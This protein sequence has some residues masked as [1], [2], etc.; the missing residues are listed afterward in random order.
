MLTAD[1]KRRIDAC[2]DIL[3]GKLPL[4]TDQVELITLALIYKFMDDLDEE[5][6]RMGGKRSFFTGPLAKYRWRN[7]L[8]QTVSAEQR[9]TLFSEGI[10]ALGDAQKSAHLPGLFRDIFRNAF[11]KFRDG[12]IL[13]LFLTE[14]NGFEYSHSEEL[15]NA[16]EYLLQSV[17]TQ[18]ENGQFR[19]PRH[20]IDFIVTCLDPQPGEKILDPACGTGG[21]LVSAYK[22]ILKCHTS[23]PSPQPSPTGRGG[24]SDMQPSPSGSGSSSDRE[25]SPTGTKDGQYRGGFTFSGLKA[26]AR[27]LRKSQTQPEALLWELLRDRQLGGAKFRRQ[28]QFGEYICDFFCAEAKLDVEC[29]GIA[30]D[31]PERRKH[32][33]KRDAWLKA[34]GITVLRFRNSQVLDATDSVLEEIAAHLPSETQPGDTHAESAPPSP[35]GRG[36]GGEGPVTTAIP[37]DKLTHAQ[38]QAVYRSLTGYDITD[39]MVKLSKVNL[40]LHGFPNPAIHIYDTLS[41]D[42]RWH[43]KADLILAN[44]PFMTPKGGVTPHTKFRIAARKAEVLFTDYIA[45]HLTPDGRAGVIVPNGIVATTQNAYVKLRRFLVEDSLVA[46]VSLPAGVF[47]PYSGVKTS[48]LLLDK[49]LARRTKEILFL[50]I[51]AD[52]FDL[53]DKRNPIE[54]NDLPEAERV[55]KAWLKGMLND[56]FRMTNVGTSATGAIGSTKG[57][58][59]TAKGAALRAEGPLPSQPGPTAQETESAPALRAESPAQRLAWKLVA[60]SELLQHRACSLQAEPFLGNGTVSAEIETVRL[61]DV[62]V[63]CEQVNPAS[64]GRPTF[65]YIDIDSVD[66]IGLRITEPKSLPVGEAPSRARKL[67]KAR[68][69]LFSTV[70]PYLKNIAIVPDSLDGE[71]ASTGFGVLRADESRVLPEYLF[72]VVS[73]QRFVDAA[74]DLTT[75]ASYPAITE[76]QLFDLEIPLPPLEEQRRI[77]AEI[78][79]YQNEIA[80]LESE[81]VANRERIQTTIDAVWNGDSESA[82]GAPPSQL[83]AAPQVKGRKHNEG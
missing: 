41:N 27:E 65:R 12:R 14:V 45:E 42:A 35:L 17:G 54:A 73:N 40:F 39:L 22:H 11:L 26:R 79:G 57:A 49:K 25:P 4:P 66:N 37:G 59:L 33:A 16:F 34:R 83:G 21:F 20:I 70:R 6:V 72:A 71:I 75:G 28:H 63:K 76:N 5:S 8:P 81:I 36:A 44:P 43:E 23:K 61:G 78:E 82:N 58:T 9:V 53:G 30:H 10:E 19:T 29:D 13:T 56:E 1:T 2:R 69:V 77:V 51:T 52:G 47:K 48:I 3:V 80:R 67:V 68:D 46:V 38:R 74:N 24:A 7:L 18:G 55:V 64:L 15:G 31:T 32:D 50:K 62:C 60:K